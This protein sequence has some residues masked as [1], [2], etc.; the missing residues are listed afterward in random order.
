MSVR[1]VRL[2]ICAGNSVDVLY[3]MQALL[4]LDN[5]FAV[6]CGCCVYGYCCVYVICVVGMNCNVCL[7]LLCLYMSPATVCKYVADC[8]VNVELNNT[9]L[10]VY[11]LSRLS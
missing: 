8:V 9:Q 4:S 1:T 7:L 3:Q 2:S 5:M 6:V 10:Y 11:T